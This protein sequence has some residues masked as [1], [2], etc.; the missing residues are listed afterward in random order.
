MRNKD[1]ELGCALNG[2]FSLL[3]NLE[4]S[5]KT[6]PIQEHR[7]K[8]LES[9]QSSQCVVIT[10]ETGCGKTT[11]F[12]QYLYKG[13][14]AG[15]GGIAVTQPRRVAAIS[16]AHRV[17]SEMD[18]QLGREVGYQVRFD[19]CSSASTKIKYMTDGCLLREFLDDKELSRYS[20][21]VLDEAHERSL[22]TDI[23]FGLVKNLLARKSFSKA[24]RSPLKVVIMSA[25]LDVTKFSRFFD[26]CPIFEIPGR[27]YPVTIMYNCTDDAF[28]TKKLTYISQLNRVIMD[29]HLDHPQGDIL[30]FLTGQSEIEN[31]CNRLFKV[32]ETID[33]D[34]DVSC[35]EVKGMLILPLFGAL[36]SEQQQRVF[37]PVEKGIRRVIIATNIA[38]TSL[39]IDGVVYVVDSGFVKQLAYNPRTG[40][41]SLEIVPI[42]Q[43]E[44]IQ[45][46]GRAGRTA[47]GKCSRL[48]SKQFYD[49]LEET[50]IPEIQRTSLTGVIL[51]IKC[52]G[53]ENVLDFQYLDPPEERMILEALRQLFY[54]QA[55]DEDGHVTALGEKLVEFP[56]QPSLAR[57]LLRSWQLDCHSA[58][59][60]I[61]AMLS[62]ENVFIRPS[63][64]EAA[65]KSLEVH[66]ELSQ[67]GGG[68]S[69]FSTL[70]A[71]YQLA[72]ESPSIRK[73]CREHYIHWRAIKTAQNI[74]QQLE[75]ILSRRH[76]PPEA[77]D[78]ASLSAPLSQRVR[79][80]LCYGLFCNAAR[81]SPS[82]R[83]FR[84]MDGHSTVAYIHPSSA[85][86][87]CEKSL[88]WL[89][90][91]ELVETAK[92]YMRTLCPVRY[93]WIQDLLP[94]LHD[95]DVYKLSS[96]EGRG[97]GVVRRDSDGGAS[98]E[99]SGLQPAVKRAR[100]ESVGG[101]E[102]S[103]PVEELKERA[104]SAK[105]RYLAR[106]AAL[107]QQLE[108]S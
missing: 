70:L 38:T 102:G 95:I 32:A 63:N 108:N 83:N 60:P 29:I 10:G 74:C 69:D 66:K 13:G 43:S 98:G 67:A 18:V 97:V 104:A 22:A 5:T 8:L 7:E 39:T 28:D 17:A 30:V 88:D 77:S 46:T 90:F 54:F 75:S 93:S 92:T 101:R 20:I 11:Q 52:M 14:L 91:M 62:V 19:D 99:G 72:T 12:P 100:R 23:L 33:Y 6:L 55:I 79:Q 65:E 27:V 26:T 2:N 105:E 21:I 73:W 49:Q 89:V 71:I 51:S 80:S 16:V 78:K 96:C 25:T 58:V 31:A 1:C 56:L 45:R 24:R 85:L 107:L 53:I 57:V 44:A 36:S 59:L 106:K 94:Q 4:M 82:R 3:L 76:L 84:T 35:A 37:D 15:D 42:A 87:G 68:T 41:D 86:F 50:T 48:Y 64:K 9:V 40:L 103:S 34:N 61:V 47:P 81:V